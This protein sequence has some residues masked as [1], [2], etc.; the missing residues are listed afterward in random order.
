MVYILPQVK[1]FQELLQRPGEITVPL[2]AHISG[3]HAFLL[4]YTPATKENGSLGLYNSL[5]ESR[6]EWPNR[7]A[8]SRIDLSS[9]RLFIED[10]LMEYF[11]D[12]VSAGSTITVTAGYRNR[13]RSDSVN[14]RANGT[15]YP[16]HASLYDRDVR[17]GDVARVR[18]VVN[19]TNYELWTHVRDIKGDIVPGSVGAATGDTNNA[20][21]QSP[22]PPAT[23]AKTGG[24]DNCVE[25][26]SVNQ[27]TYDGRR[28]GDINETYTILV[29]QSS[30]NGDAT[31]ARLRVFSASG[32][33]NQ[34][35]VT[36]AA[37][38]SPT[39]IGTRGLT[40]TFDLDVGAAC[41][42]AAE[43]DD[44]SPNDF[45]AG[46]RWQVTCH[47]NFTAPTATSG[48]TYTGA[49]D[50]TYI[51]TVTRGGAYAS[52]PQI[53]VS[54]TTGYDRSGPTTVPAA[55]T[56]VPVGSHGV[57]I[58]FNQ[59]GLR[60]GDRYYISV[61]APHEGPM[62]TL[63]LAHNLDAGI[64]A[65]TEVDLT[66]YIR[67]SFEITRERHGFAPQL[68]WEASNEELIVHPELVATDPSWTNN[69]VPMFL[70]VTSESTRQYGRLYVEYRAWLSE[71]CDVIG[72][73][74]T[75][76]ELDERISG[77]LHPSNPLKWG[78]FKAL[79]NSNGV[80]VKFTSVCDPE[81]LNSWLKVLDTIDGVEGVY[82]LVPLTFRN[83]II[84][85]FLGHAKEQSSPERNNFRVVWAALEDVPAR[86]IVGQRP[87]T[88]DAPVL[89]IVQDDPNKSG[90][91][92]TLLQVPAHNGNFVSR[93]VR[94]LDR[95]RI[96][97]TTDG[98]GN[99]TYQE[100]VIDA[101]INEDELRLVS[102]PSSPITVPERI[103]IWRTL[104]P[105]DRAQAIA[106]VNN[107]NHR[108]LRKIWPDQ[109]GSDGLTYPGYH[110][111]A[112]LAALSS[113]VRPHQGLTNVEIVGF[114]D[115][116]RT[117]HLFGRSQLDLMAG[118]GVW[119]VTQDPATGAVYT[120]HAV[121]SGDYNNIS[122]REE[123]ITR[124]L[125]SISFS[126]YKM[127]VPF[128]GKAN[129]APGALGT[130]RGLLE[131]ALDGMQR[132]GSETILGGQV[133]GYVID[134]LDVHPVLRDHLIIDLRLR[135]PVALNVIELHLIV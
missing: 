99:E 120:R 83:D 133:L 117:T 113:G 84:S 112:A 54:T 70:E 121:T 89:A 22:P 66:L 46:Q 119:I 98:F 94:P 72:E 122:D 42:S 20:T 59:T 27:A 110:L 3:G 114:D 77:E 24:P 52:G 105:T 85:A 23:F 9:V 71:L 35:S 82:G 134:R 25:I 61:V 64:P 90:T 128:I 14:F 91:Q 32:N 107:W 13:I 51:V 111:A 67:K 36:P 44:V 19:S 135:L 11:R 81:D 37:F 100:Y 33:D 80:P 63:V 55:A 124:N 31:T 86:M 92:Y 74:T 53:T 73:V 29:T 49:S 118:S 7:P 40:V 130:I 106:R 58:S 76:G 38:G 21:T 17:V 97:Y 60:K 26:A 125:D 28:D 102:G 5:V 104:N 75:I 116:S 30:I 41:S 10:A 47:Q 88:Q 57:T 123:M 2:S 95:V 62:R 79:Q 132:R 56:A 18:A 12:A 43:E 65:N 103:E 108:R 1:V 109:V 6:Y 93:R 15:A 50:T 126:L 87:G 68:N 69:G 101:V 127:L 131:M 78:V 96:Q 115:L 48:G 129:L 4:R 16:R 45:I 8:G 39:P 34:L